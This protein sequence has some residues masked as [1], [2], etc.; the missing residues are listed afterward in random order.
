[1]LQTLLNASSF[2]FSAEMI[3]LLLYY[4]IIALVIAVTLI[5]MG[6]L[7]RKTKSELKPEKIK[8]ACLKAKKYAEDIL[9]SGEHKG[10]HALL[11]ATKLSNL[12]KHIANAAWYGF[13][14]V[15]EKKDIVIEGIANE[16]DALATELANESADGYVPANQYE[17]DVQ[18]AIDGL[19]STLVKLDALI[20][21]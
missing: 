7:R 3:K 11:G 10:T 4:G 20:K 6:V 5:V 12:S 8:K 15:S 19:N 21:K 14:I 18:K 17:K 16:L 13:Q 9:A 1:M 2:S